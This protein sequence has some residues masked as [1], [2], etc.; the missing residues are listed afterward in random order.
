M[1]ARV[2]LNWH[3]QHPIQQKTPLTGNT[4][5]RA[6]KGALYEGAPG[7]LTGLILN[8]T[9]L[10]TICCSHTSLSA[11]LNTFYTHPH[12]GAFA[13]ALLPGT[14]C[15]IL[16]SFSSFQSLLLY[17]PP[18]Q[19][20]FLTRKTAVPPHVSPP[21]SHRPPFPTF[22]VLTL[23]AT[24]FFDPCCPPLP[25]PRHNGRIWRCPLPP[26]PVRPPAPRNDTAIH[27]ETESV[28]A[29]PPSSP[30]PRA[31]QGVGLGPD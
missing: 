7:G 12:V 15:P 14:V 22:S 5:S 1:I 11:S 20:A 6:P 27:R 9:P 13:Y 23:P 25:S 8:L 17:A 4:V 10:H 16:P 21:G 31:R 28:S 18:H 29:Y 3:N 30:A 26:T 2:F 19:N 24:W